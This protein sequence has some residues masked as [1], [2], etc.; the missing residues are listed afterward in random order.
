MTEV[1][2]IAPRGEEE[3]GSREGKPISDAA[4]SPVVAQVAAPLDHHTVKKEDGLPS[5]SPNLGAAVN[6]VTYRIPSY[7]GWFSWDKIHSIEQRALP[8]FFDGNSL[9]KTPKV[10]KEYRDFI[11]NRYREHPQRSLTYSEVRKMLVGDVNLIRKV[12]D[13]IEYWGLIN[14]HTA[15]ENKNQTAATDS[16]HASHMSGNIP[17]GIRIV[18]PC[19]IVHPKG[20][21]PSNERPAS[22]SNLASHKDLFTGWSPMNLQA[23]PIEESIDRQASQSC[24]NCG[25][26]GESKWFENKK[27]TGFIL[28]EACFSAGD[29]YLKDDFTLAETTSESERNHLA[30]TKEEALRLLEAIEKHG[31]NW[32]RVALHVGTKSKAECIMHFMKLPFGDQFCSGIMSLDAL[33]ASRS[34]DETIVKNTKVEQRDSKGGGEALELHDN[35]ELL[36]SIED[37]DGPPTKWRR[38][39]PLADSSNPILAQVAF[40]SA[41]VGPRVAAATAQ[42]ALMAISEDDPVAAQ[43]LSAVQPGHKDPFLPTTTSKDS[44]KADEEKKEDAV[45]R[46]EEHVQS[47]KT[48]EV[49][50]SSSKENLPSTTQIR[51]AIATAIGAVAANAKLL[52]DQEERETEYLMAT[53]IENQ[54]KKLE[55]K[56]QHFEEL[57]HLLEVDHGHVERAQMQLESSV[58]LY[59]NHSRRSQH[60]FCR[61]SSLTWGDIHYGQQSLEACPGSKCSGLF[62]GT[63]IF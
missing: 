12:F 60:S 45:M 62:F 22:I 41:M 50:T 29:G 16:A 10:Y 42:A 15:I 47:S 28:C 49:E 36:E 56:V 63:M 34:T 9:S 32:D 26:N 38:L 21:V 31:E 48:G 51:A 57:E 37:A 5:S 17:P 59:V 44:S 8:E 27:K 39:N 6:K 53:I 58:S 13:C 25:M 33:A 23:V 54:L 3:G 19:K 46:T 11:V 20:Q 18:Y 4:G 35:E 30:W 61:Q 2:R 24:S 7:A 55:S 1:V 14:N 40:L 52:A 43:F